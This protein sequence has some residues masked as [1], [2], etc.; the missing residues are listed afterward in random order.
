[1]M[2]MS[3]PKKKL[4]MVSFLGVLPLLLL[5]PLF[6]FANHEPCTAI[7]YDFGMGQGNIVPCGPSANTTSSGVNIEDSGG[8]TT[9]P[10][11]GSCGLPGDG[12][13]PMDVQWVTFVIQEGGSF[14]WQTVPGSDDF[15]WEMWV[16]NNPVDV[17]GEEDPGGN[18]PGVCDDLSYVDCDTEFTGWRV[19]STPDPTKK[20]RFYIAYYLRNGDQSGDG[21]VKIRKSCG[22]ACVGSDISVTASDDVCIESGANTMLDANASG[23][24]DAP[25]TYFWTPTSSLNNPQIKSPLASPTT[26]TTYTVVA[27]GADGCPASDQVTVTVGNCCIAESGTLSNNGAGAWPQTLCVGKNDL[28]TVTFTA[29]GFQSNVAYGYALF[30]VD[31]D[32]NISNAVAGASGSFTFSGLSAGTYTVYGISYKGST[33]D[34]PTNNAEAQTYV[35]GFATLAALLADIPPTC[36]EVVSGGSGNQVTILGVNCGTFN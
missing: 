14:E 32:G 27:A 28:N 12:G 17:P 18:V 5:L 26:T 36:A 19:E 10:L 16:S 31:A 2:K 24:G 11:N 20:W 15:I 13:S 21:V 3:T 6:S 4:G 34:I 25:Y 23:G 9:F 8:T 35:N 7:P 1:M 22:E 33:S 29:T 30:L